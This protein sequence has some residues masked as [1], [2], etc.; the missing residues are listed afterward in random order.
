MHFSCSPSTT[1]FVYIYSLANSPRSFVVSVGCALRTLPVHRPPTTAAGFPDLVVVGT[2]IPF[3]ITTSFNVSTATNGDRLFGVD[4]STGIVRW[5]A[6]P[7]AKKG[8]TV[9]AL[10]AVEGGESGCPAFL[11][12]M[13]DSQK[14]VLTLWEVPSADG[15]ARPHPVWMLD[16]A[17][18][19]I[20][21]LV[22]ASSV[23]S[24]SHGGARVPLDNPVVL[25]GCMDKTVRA[26][27]LNDGIQLWSTVAVPTREWHGGYG[28][29]GGRE[30]G[31][32]GG[33]DT[34]GKKTKLRNRYTFLPDRPP[35]A[36]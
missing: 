2:G 7:S 36:L 10:V 23:A 33:L 12:G 28:G 31:M 22:A 20:T 35:F 34:V 11:T 13:G 8:D 25:V 4:P 32:Q 9:T 27:G 5:R 3:A 17:C 24:S 18:K 30:T 29:E 14:Q 19:E 26:V 6:A 21:C 15:A 16:M 1:S